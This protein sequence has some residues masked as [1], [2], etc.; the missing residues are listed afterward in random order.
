MGPLG[1]PG[2]CGRGSAYGSTVVQKVVRLQ[3][4]RFS[5]QNFFKPFKPEAQSTDISLL[6]IRYCAALFQPKQQ[7]IYYLHEIFYVVSYSEEGRTA[8]AI[9]TNPERVFRFSP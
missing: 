4:G 6:I 7:P 1:Q 2:R 3:E 5:E 9:E 8:L